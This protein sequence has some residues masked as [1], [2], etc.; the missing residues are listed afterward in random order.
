MFAV[1]VPDYEVQ[2]IFWA[3][4]HYEGA[5]LFRDTA[6]LEITP[7]D[8]NDENGSWTVRYWWA[9]DKNNVRTEPVLFNANKLEHVIELPFVNQERPG[10]VGK[11][12]LVVRPWK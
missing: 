11:L 12:R 10:I 2:R 6:F 8:D 1:K 7:P 5:D 4:G 9:A 3:D